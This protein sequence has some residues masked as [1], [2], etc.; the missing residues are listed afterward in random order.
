MA[1][2]DLNQLLNSL[3]PFAKRMLAEHGEFY[4]FGSTMKPN[5]EIVAVGA[6]DGDEHPPSQNL[7]DFMTQAFSQQA[8]TGQLRAAA[9][10]YDVRTIPPGQTEK[11]DAVCA[12]LEHQSGEAVNV[13]VPYQKA[14]DGGIRYMQ[15]FATARTPQFFV[16]H[17]TSLEFHHDNLAKMAVVSRPFTLIE[18]RRLGR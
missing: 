9:I 3:L 2:P 16:L 18:D 6:Y 1:H 8:K 13:F 11:C 7:I 15:L 14:T 12:S 17:K 4:P 5:G 10:C